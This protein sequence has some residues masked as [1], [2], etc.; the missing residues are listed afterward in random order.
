[1]KGDLNLKKETKATMKKAAKWTLFLLPVALVGGFF[2]GMYTYEHYD[3][4]TIELILQQIGSYQT[5]LA[6]TTVQSAVYGCVAAFLG[7]LLA[8]SIGLVKPFRFEKEKL[9][10]TLPIIVL[11]GVLFACDYF[12]FGSIIPEVAADYQKG[13]SPAYFLCSLT[14]GGVVEE[15]LLRWFFMSLIAWILRKLFV[16]GK[17][18]D[19]IPAWVFI[20]ANIIAALVFSAGHL[21]TTVSLYGGLSPWIVFRCFLL[22][23]CFAMVFGRFYRK[24][25][26]QYAM[27]GHFGLHLVSKLI[28]LF[29]I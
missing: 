26:I 4:N 18:K 17:A 21:P 6:L 12:V 20:T 7:Y 10:H 19:E 1:M 13:I 3:K 16:S 14:Y 28:L 23:G 8:D 2:T 24:Y 27:L 11:L 22:N 29:V 25:G 9:R 15:V 5:F